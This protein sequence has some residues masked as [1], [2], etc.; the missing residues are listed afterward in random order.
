MLTPSAV[1]VLTPTPATAPTSAPAPASR[2]TSSSYLSAKKR[3]KSLLPKPELEEPKA[4]AARVMGVS[5]VREAKRNQANHN[6]TSTTGG[7]IASHRNQGWWREA[8]AV[9]ISRTFELWLHVTKV[10]PC[11]SLVPRS[12]QPMTR[13]HI[14]PHRRFVQGRAKVVIDVVQV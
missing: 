2:C 1:S 5:P 7:P 13:L 4:E 9:G 8:S 12:E 6:S 3:S 11:P 14:S 10:K